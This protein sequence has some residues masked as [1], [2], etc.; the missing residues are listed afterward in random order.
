MKE[1]AKKI[2]EKLEV[3]DRRIIFVF[4]FLSI[5]LPLLLPVNMEFSV[6][7]PVKSFYD[8]I[9]SLP[10]GSKVLVSCDYDP[11]SMPELFP[12]NIAA[13]YHLLSVGIIKVRSIILE[14][15]VFEQIISNL[16]FCQVLNERIQRQPDMVS[17]NKLALVNAPELTIST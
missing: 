6:T 8:A 1:T 15:F 3:L 9:E 16:R 7:P 4:I 2:L 5:A 12:M 17:K 11:G 10:P 14:G 13:F